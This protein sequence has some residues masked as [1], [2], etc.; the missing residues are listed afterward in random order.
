MVMHS[1]RCSPLEFN[2][3]GTSVGWLLDGEKD[4]AYYY[5]DQLDAPSF[6]EEC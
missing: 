6:G 2:P 3:V 1:H 5:K 4:A